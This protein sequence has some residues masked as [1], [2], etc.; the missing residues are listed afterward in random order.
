MWS[1]LSDC[2]CSGLDLPKVD[3]VIHYQTPRSSELYIHRSGRSARAGNAGR[4]L[5]LVSEKEQQAYKKLS[6]G[7]RRSS[8]HLSLR[9]V[10]CACDLHIN[11]VC[12]SYRAYRLWKWIYRTCH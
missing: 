2:T 7:L 9:R 10:P 12:V 4:S 8:V 6:S 5:L 11:A 3:S 1:L